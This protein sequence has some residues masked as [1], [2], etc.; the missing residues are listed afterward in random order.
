MKLPAAPQAGSP[1]CCDKLRGIK[2]EFAE[3][4]PP[5]LFKLPTSLKLR[6][7]KSARSPRHPCRAV[8]FGGG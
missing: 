3:A 2:S 5:S 8:A 7:D 4:N 6:Q 1:L